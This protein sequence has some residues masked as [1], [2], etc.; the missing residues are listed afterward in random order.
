MTAKNFITHWFCR[1]DEKLA[2]R[3]K[4]RKH[5]QS[6]LHPFWECWNGVVFQVSIFHLCLTNVYVL[7]YQRLARGGKISRFSDASW[8]SPKEYRDSLL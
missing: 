1:V 7:P 8:A 2:S 3:K 6:N 5:S 4:N